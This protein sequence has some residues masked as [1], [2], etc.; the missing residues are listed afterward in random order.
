MVHLMLVDPIPEA[1]ATAAETLG[2]LVERLE[3]VHFPDLVP[4]LLRTLKTE[5][6]SI[7]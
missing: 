6:S 3:E 5:T 4:G 1:C 2:T 7:D